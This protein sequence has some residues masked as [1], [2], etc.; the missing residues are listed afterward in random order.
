M[1]KKMAPKAVKGRTATRMAND[2]KIA[3][4]IKVRPS[5]EKASGKTTRSIA[6]D[7]RAAGKIGLKGA[8]RKPAAMSSGKS[9]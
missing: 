7:Y 8:D 1:A 5:A 9:G 4:G 2:K 6:R 3:G